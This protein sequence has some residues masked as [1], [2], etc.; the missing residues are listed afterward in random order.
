MKIFDI[1]M[2]KK[3]G[4]M[5]LRSSDSYTCIFYKEE[6][7]SGNTSLY[8]TCLIY[9]FMQKNNNFKSFISTLSKLNRVNYVIVLNKYTISNITLYNL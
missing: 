2:F 1:N 8:L 7:H 5:G 3:S 4:S 9:S 6:T